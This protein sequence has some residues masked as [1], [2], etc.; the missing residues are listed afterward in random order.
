M[1]GAK[2]FKVE[3]FIKYTWTY[4]KG[5]LS[6]YLLQILFKFYF[7]SRRLTFKWDALLKALLHRWHTWI[8]SFP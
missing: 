2:Y 4:E 7:Q 8:R 1:F 6:L 5:H 3:H